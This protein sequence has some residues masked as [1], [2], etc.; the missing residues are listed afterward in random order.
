MRSTVKSVFLSH[1]V[2]DLIHEGISI[3]NFNNLLPAEGVAAATVSYTIMAG[4]HIFGAVS[5]Q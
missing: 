3:N 5:L 2:A 4:Q 1:Y